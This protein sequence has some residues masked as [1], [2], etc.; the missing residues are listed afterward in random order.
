MASRTRLL[1]LHEGENG[2]SIDPIFIR[3]VIKELGPKWVRPWDGNNIIRT[4]DK[5]GRTELI[6]ALPQ[7]IRTAREVGSS[8]TIMVWADLDHDM[9]DGEALKD[10]FWKTCQEGGVRRSEF[11][12][13]VFV[14]AKDRLE[15]WIQYLN[16][17]TTDES[18]EGPR[19]KYP[20]EAATAARTLARICKENRATSDLPK[21]LVWS[22]GNWRRALAEL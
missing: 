7:E 16:L 18:L 1:C 21:S 22:C 12:Q 8:L 20:K 2:R 3:E 15:N 19:V 10:R 14:F 4:V 17:G 9:A 13:V 6:G 11:D 5:G